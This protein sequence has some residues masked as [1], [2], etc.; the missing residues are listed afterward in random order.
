MVQEAGTGS[1]GAGSGQGLTLALDTALDDELR[2]EGLCREL[3]N[4]VQNLR[5]KSGLEVSDRIELVVAGAP[6]VLEVV[7]KH[8]ERIMADTL[9][10]AVASAGEMPYKESF[11][12]DELE[13][14]IALGKV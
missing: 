4:K 11:S 8:S 13:I 12:I 7:Q 1:F 6:A 2:S 10:V 3:I 9:A 14:T 5:K